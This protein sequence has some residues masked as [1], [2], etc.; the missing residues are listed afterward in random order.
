MNFLKVVFHKL[1]SV[2]YWIPW[3]KSIK[4]TCYVKYFQI[5][6][7]LSPPVTTVFTFFDVY[8]FWPPPH[9]TPPH[10]RLII[11]EVEIWKINYPSPSYLRASKKKW[12]KICVSNSAFQC[13]QTNTLLRCKQRM[14]NNA[15]TTALLEQSPFI[16]IWLFSKTIRLFWP[17]NYRAF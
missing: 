14:W 13:L 12:E 10:P 15:Y 6:P 9:P 4:N 17:H 2:H 16:D 3:P 5:N 1:Y 8:L 11:W 7:L